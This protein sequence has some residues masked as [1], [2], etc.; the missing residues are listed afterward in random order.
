MLFDKY[1]SH[2]TN[3]CPWA[4]SPMGKNRHL[5]GTGLWH[6]WNNRY[7]MA[8]LEL[9]FI[10]KNVKNSFAHSRTSFAHTRKLTAQW[11][12]MLVCHSLNAILRKKLLILCTQKRLGTNLDKIDSRRKLFFYLWV[13]R[14]SIFWHQIITKV[15]K[16]PKE[17]WSIR[18]EVM[19]E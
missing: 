4:S 16:T 2:W 18:P 10:I 17:F 14:K 1:K 15:S 19:I 6:L 13:S 7:K 12:P 11:T 3:L 9:N 5:P 8:N